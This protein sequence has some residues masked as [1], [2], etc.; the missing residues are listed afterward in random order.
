MQL[1]AKFPPA[2]DLPQEIAVLID[3]LLNGLAMQTLLGVTGI[4]KTLALA[5]VIDAE[6]RPELILAHNKNLSVQLYGVMREEVG[7]FTQGGV[8]AFPIKLQIGGLRARFHPKDG[9]L[10]V[11]GL[12]GW[13]TTGL[14]NGCL[15]RVR[16][17]CA[18]LRMPV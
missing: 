6:Q 11:A 3:G 13:Q 16:Y 18:P 10:C 8:A 2:V 7:G 15:Q 4:G 17:T 9:Q 1:T 5:N 14:K 12:R